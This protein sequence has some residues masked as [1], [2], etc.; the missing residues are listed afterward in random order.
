MRKRVVCVTRR[1]RGEDPHRHIAYLGV[2][3]D[4]GWSQMLMAEEVVMQLQRADGDRF[5]LRGG[6]GWEAELRLGRCPFCRDNHLALCSAPDLS[7][8][9]KLLTLGSCG[10]P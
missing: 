8:S 7:A 10:E 2:G 4:Q 1:P 6:D 9:D 5:Y 3:D